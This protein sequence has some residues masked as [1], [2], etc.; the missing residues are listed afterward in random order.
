MSFVGI[1]DGLSVDGFQVE[2]TLIS[3]KMTLPPDPL[4]VKEIRRQCCSG[5]FEY[6]TRLTA[7]HPG[8]PRSPQTFGLELGLTRPGLVNHYLA[9][10][11][12]RAT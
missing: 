4:V 2:L 6:Q 11:Q 7:R 9:P 10:S 8:L 1:L 3:R 12:H 5:T